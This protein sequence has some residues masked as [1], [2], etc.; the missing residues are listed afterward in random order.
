MPAVNNAS[1]FRLLLTF[2]TRC[3]PRNRR[4]LV[5]SFESDAFVVEIGM[6]KERLQIPTIGIQKRWQIDN[7]RCTGQKRTTFPSNRS[8]TSVLI[9]AAFRFSKQRVRYVSARDRTHDPGM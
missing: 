9:G 7:S 2:L 5:I 4:G 1:A 6:W 8:R 3:A